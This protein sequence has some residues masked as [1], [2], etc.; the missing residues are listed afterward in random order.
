M[1]KVKR[2]LDESNGQVRTWEDR[3]P[4]GGFSTSARKQSV[5]A[6]PANSISILHDGVC[7]ISSVQGERK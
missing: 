7:T 1:T 6:A 2:S 4:D 3:D 5:G